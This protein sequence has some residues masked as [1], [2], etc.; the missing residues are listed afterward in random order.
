MFE[1]IIP[2][3]SYVLVEPLFHFFTSDVYFAYTF[4]VLVTFLILLFFMK[5][6]GLKFKFRLAS[7]LVGFL[8]FIVWVLLE[9]FKFSESVFQPPT[10]F[11]F[12]VKF[13]GA[14][15]V[16]SFVEELFTRSFLIRLFVNTRIER[17]K[18]GVF[19]PL[20][21]IVTVLFFGFS[22]NMWL[23]GLVVGVIL[24]LW[25]YKTKSVEQ[26]IIAHGTAN[27]LLFFYVLSNHAYTLW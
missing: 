7:F 12:F 22:H 9:S 2:F 11:F 10:S 18:P 19:T 1:Y 21:F 23:A 3:L 27:L 15:F 6:Y 13:F 20:S 4:K 14:V 16:A 26:C 5:R 17:V 25:Y 8:V 24:N